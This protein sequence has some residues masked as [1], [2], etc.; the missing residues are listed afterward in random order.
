LGAL[1]HIQRTQR[2]IDG[3]L[4][5]RKLLL[6]LSVLVGFRFSLLVFVQFLHG[7]FPLIDGLDLAIDSI[8]LVLIGIPS[9]F[10]DHVITPKILPGG[11]GEKKSAQ[12]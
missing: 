12:C 4:E 8:G 7:D 3:V 2:L 9:S 5:L 10:H 6:T 11:E 1:H